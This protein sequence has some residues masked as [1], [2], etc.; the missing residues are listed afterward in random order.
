MYVWTC[1]SARIA[2]HA[3]DRA[4]A[5]LTW[6]CT[7]TRTLLHSKNQ[8]AAP[9]QFQANKGHIFW[10]HNQPDA[11]D[12][13]AAPSLY[14]S[15]GEPLPRTS[16]PP[17]PQTAYR[18]NRKT[19][20]SI[21]LHRGRPWK[22]QADVFTAK[23]AADHCQNAK[24]LAQ[25]RKSTIYFSACVDSS[26]HLSI[27]LFIHSIIHSFVHLFLH[28]IASSPSLIFFSLPLFFPPSLPST[29][30]PFLP[31]G[32]QRTRLEGQVPS[33]SRFTG[34]HVEGLPKAKYT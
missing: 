19:S 12:T 3:H 32:R 20:G 25:W 6:S 1:E 21:M 5:C 33:L 22:C 29:L 17:R 26:I 24:P 18:E 13:A 4:R 2:A 16:S 11:A 30:L 23:E 8:F 14:A 34:N 28:S 9:G 27:H 15:S 31:F 7:L 10:R